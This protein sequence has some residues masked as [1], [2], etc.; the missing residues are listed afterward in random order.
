M[1]N[2]LVLS[3]MQKILFLRK[4]LA[5]A[6]ECILL[7]FVLKNLIGNLGLF[8]SDENFRAKI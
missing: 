3:I 8:I 5:V 6:S 2:L 1:A 4:Y 7:D